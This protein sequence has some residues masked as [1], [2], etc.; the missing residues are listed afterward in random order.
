VSGITIESA[1]GVALRF[2][3]DFARKVTLTAHPAPPT[4][5]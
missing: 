4:A 1:R 5:P 2:R 3:E